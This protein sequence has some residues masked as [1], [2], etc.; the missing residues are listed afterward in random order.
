MDV[1]STTI[2]LTK[3]CSVRAMMRQGA[4]AVFITDTSTQVKAVFAALTT[5]HKISLTDSIV[6]I[7]LIV[8]LGADCLESERPMTL[9][10]L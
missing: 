6:P 3:Q 9:S 2:I 7:F 8:V 10:F 5:R 4:P 1:A